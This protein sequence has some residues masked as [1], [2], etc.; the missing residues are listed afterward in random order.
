MEGM[1]WGVCLLKKKTSHTKT[2]RLANVRRGNYDF[3]YLFFWSKDFYLSFS[4]SFFYKKIKLQCKTSTTTRTNEIKIKTL[5]NQKRQTIL[6]NTML[7]RGV[8]KVSQSIYNET[9]FTWNI[10]EFDI[11]KLSIDVIDN[12]FET[13]IN[14]AFF[15]DIVYN[16]LGVSFHL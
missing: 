4:F 15:I 5:K 13:P 9:R 14:R 10:R 3:T 1:R 16:Q 6:P 8:S 2:K 11:S 7:T 12:Y